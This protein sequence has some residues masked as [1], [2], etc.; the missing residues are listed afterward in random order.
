MNFSLYTSRSLTQ[1]AGSLLCYCTLDIYTVAEDAAYE[2]ISK[3][4]YFTFL[5][6]PVKTK[7]QYLAMLIDDATVS[8]KHSLAT[9]TVHSMISARMEKLP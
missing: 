7:L 4:S 6:T 1:L 5:Y 9:P 8:K 3:W 2:T